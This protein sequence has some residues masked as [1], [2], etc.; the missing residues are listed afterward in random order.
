[1]DLVVGRNEW[2]V[3]EWKEGRR[4]K[5]ELFKPLREGKA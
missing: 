2:K 4:S 5:S 1:M 3:L